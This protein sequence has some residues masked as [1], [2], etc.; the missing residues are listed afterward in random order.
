MNYDQRRKVGRAL[1]MFRKKTGKTVEAL[2]K[3][4]GWEP[5]FYVLAELGKASL[6]EGQQ[7]DVRRVM[8]ADIKSATIRDT[9][10]RGV[11][12]RLIRGRM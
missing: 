12:R 2:A 5:A 7:N 8:K 10:V 4:L 6:S 11:P 9:L 3:E 1:R